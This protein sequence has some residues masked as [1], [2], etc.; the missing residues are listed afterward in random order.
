M[1]KKQ[2]F[3]H[4]TPIC[5]T[6]LFQSCHAPLRKPIRN[7]NKSAMIHGNNILRPVS[8]CNSGLNQIMDHPSFSLSSLFLVYNLRTNYLFLS[9]VLEIPVVYDLSILAKHWMIGI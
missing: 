9:Y 6:G 2:E 5:E 8:T 3:H 1:V 7:G 4:V